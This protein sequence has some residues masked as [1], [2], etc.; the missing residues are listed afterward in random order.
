MGREAN[1]CRDEW[2]LYLK[3]PAL[4]GIRMNKV[5]VLILDPFEKT[6]VG[7]DFNS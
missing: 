3:V 2:G 7:G 5:K 1:C 6:C 4:C